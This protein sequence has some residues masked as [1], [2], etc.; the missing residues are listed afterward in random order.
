MAQMVAGH[1]HCKHPGQGVAKSAGIASFEQR[2]INTILTA[3]NRH[4]ADIEEF[5]F[6]QLRN[7]RIKDFTPS[8][9]NSAAFR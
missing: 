4:L 6:G 7:W 9:N 3:P 8:K 1:R 2:Q 5:D